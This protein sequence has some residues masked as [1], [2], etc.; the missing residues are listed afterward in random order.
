[1]CFPM[2]CQCGYLCHT[3]INV[4]K[5][6]TGRREGLR[7]ETK[8]C[9]A[10]G[11][12]TRGIASQSVIYH[13]RLA[14]PRLARLHRR[15]WFYRPLNIIKLYDV[16]YA[17]RTAIRIGATAAATV[18]KMVEERAQITI[19]QEIESLV[20]QN[21]IV[22]ESCPGHWRADAESRRGC[23]TVGPW[24]PAWGPAE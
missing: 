13:Y 12:R 19:C 4:Y 3:H 14:C 2:S 1:M 24:C 17:T 20:I 8:R 7:L 15:S 5:R 23:R 10:E 6:V 16:E 18:C 21:C 9:E 22:F 11:Q